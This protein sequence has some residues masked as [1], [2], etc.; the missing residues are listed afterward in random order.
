VGAIAF[1]PLPAGIPL[2]DAAMPHDVVAG[3][4]SGTQRV[5]RPFKAA[6]KRVAE[7]AEDCN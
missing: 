4:G 3:G 7:N 1:K 5:A 2:R 6:A